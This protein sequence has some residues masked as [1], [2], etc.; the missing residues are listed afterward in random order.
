MKSPRWPVAGS[1]LLS[2]LLLLPMLGMLLWSRLDA[3]RFLSMVA[4]DS[5]A[6]LFRGPNLEKRLGL[7]ASGRH[8]WICWWRLAPALW[9]LIALQLV[10]ERAT[11]SAFVF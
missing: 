8:I 4:G 11:S 10:I 1:M 5:S 6:V 9:R 3:A 7:N 2:L